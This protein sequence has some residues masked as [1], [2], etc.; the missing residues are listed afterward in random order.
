MHQ[1]SWTIYKAPQPLLYFLSLFYICIWNSVLLIWPMF[2]HLQIGRSIHAR[3][4]F[5][6]AKRLGV[7]IGSCWGA[8]FFLYLAKKSTW[9][10]FLETLGDAIVVFQWPS[11]FQCRSRPPFLLVS[12]GGIAWGTVG[13]EW[14]VALD[15]STSSFQ[16][17]IFFLMSLSVSN[18]TIGHL[19]TYSPFSLLQ[20]TRFNSSVS[21]QFLH[22]TILASQ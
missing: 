3:S 11:F 13:K 4:F 12:I 21:T 10:W 18:G 9:E 7:E 14:L 22:W 1:E 19:F 20:Q 2:S 5:L 16:L 8:V 15:L 17:S 6:N